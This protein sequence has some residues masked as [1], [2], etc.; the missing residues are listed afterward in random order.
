VIAFL[1]ALSLV[2]YCDTPTA[3]IDLTSEPI[4]VC[5]DEDGNA[6]GGPL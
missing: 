3:W 4:A 1:I 5:G 2:R 6:I